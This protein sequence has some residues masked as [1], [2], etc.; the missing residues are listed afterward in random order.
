MLGH[1]SV[2]TTEKYY[3]RFCNSVLQQAARATPGKPTIGPREASGR[4]GRSDAS[5]RNSKGSHLRDLNSRPTVYEG[6]AVANEAAGLRYDEPTG[7]LVARA[8]VFLEAV[9]AGSEHAIALGTELAN[10]VLDVAGQDAVAAAE[11]A[12]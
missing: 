4:L 11:V 8:R 2:T 5:R 3:A 6:V 10:A 9:A 1:A 12:S 7:G